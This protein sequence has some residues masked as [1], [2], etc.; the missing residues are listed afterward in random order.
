M[1]YPTATQIE[2]EAAQAGLTMKAVFAQA[3]VGP[4]SFYREKRGDGRM[5][6]RTAFSLMKA[7]S[8]LTGD[9]Q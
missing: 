6:A 9:A 5:T 7:V 3:R 4:E 8:A 1:T 2:L